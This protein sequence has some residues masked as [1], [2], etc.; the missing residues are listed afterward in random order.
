MEYETPVLLSMIA[1]A[2]LLLIQFVLRFNIN[3]DEFFFLSKVHAYLAG[4]LTGRLQSLHVHFFTWLT[5]VSE[6]EVDQIVAARL[7]MLVLHGLTAFLLY[8]IAARATDRPSSLFAALAYLSMSY[9]FRGGSSFRVDPIAIFF[10]LAAFDLIVLR[11]TNALRTAFAGTLFGIAGMV[12]IK[13]AIFFPSFIFILALPVFFNEHRTEAAHRLTLGLGAA[14]GGFALFYWLHDLSLAIAPSSGSSDVASGGFAKT[15]LDAGLF[16][17]FPIFLMSLLNDLGVWAFIAAGGI[18][19]VLRLTTTRAIDRFL[20]LEI[21]ALA[22]PLGALLIYRNS[23]PYFYGFLMAPVAILVAIAWQALGTHRLKGWIGFGVPT[24]KLLT[25]VILLFNLISQ[26][27]FGPRD[28]P[29]EHQRQVLDVI[30]RAFPEPVHYFDRSS[31]VA[32]YSQAGFFMSTW[33]MDSYRAAGKR[34]FARAIAEKGPPLLIADHPLLDLENKVYPL[35]THYGHRLLP[36]DRAALDAA[37]VHHWGP[38][39]V[40]GAQVLFEDPARPKTVNIAV[41]GPYTL[42]TV[43]PVTIEGSLVQPG[44]NLTLSR[45]PHEIKASETPLPVTLR[46]G[47][48]LYR[49]DEPAPNMPFFLGF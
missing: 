25:V 20:W 5:A 42:E 8:R 36:D 24:I 48:D 22:A 41:A 32:S 3:W 47:K 21:A 40:A 17:Q 38:I 31:I 7:V 9:V 2:L 27:T 35:G 10:I 43:H 29:L 30:H 44:E 14:V 15:L 12:T 1:L 6:N 19:T 13:T 26:G 46:W 45:G 49:P 4:D 39:Y 18:L 28:K 16:P 37:Y 11:K 23:F 33:G 34:V